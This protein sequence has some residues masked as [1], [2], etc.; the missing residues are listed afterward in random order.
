MTSDEINALPEKVRGYVHDLQANC[1]PAGNV[2]TIAS[3]K[4][5]VDG[6]SFKCDSYFNCLAQVSEKIRNGDELD[7]DTFQYL[8]RINNIEI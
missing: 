7:L 6:L 1:D 4:E 3:L 5:Q 8:T 2:Q